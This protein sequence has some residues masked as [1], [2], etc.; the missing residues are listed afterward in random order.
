M[1][2]NSIKYINSYH[3]IFNFP[4]K[5]FKKPYKYAERNKTKYNK[6]DMSKIKRLN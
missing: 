2:F 6:L 3:N 1:L 5:I 4:G